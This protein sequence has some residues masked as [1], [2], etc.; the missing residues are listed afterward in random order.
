[1]FFSQFGD[2]NGMGINWVKFVADEGAGNKIWHAVVL[3]F[4]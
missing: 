1:M 2:M 4:S 3:A